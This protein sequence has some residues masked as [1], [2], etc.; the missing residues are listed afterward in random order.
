MNNRNGPRLWDALLDTVGRHWE[1]RI[2]A[3]SVEAYQE[4]CAPDRVEIEVPA[5]MAD[6]FTSIIESLP[7]R[8][9]DG[10]ITAEPSDY[11]ERDDDNGC[12]EGEI[13]GVPVLIV[14]YVPKE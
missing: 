2:G 5:R 8:L 12:W 1:P 7:A 6:D 11:A 10:N 14:G 9:C 4:C 3:A 13:I